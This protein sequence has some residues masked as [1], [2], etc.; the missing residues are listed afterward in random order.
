MN[1]FI[2]QIEDLS[3]EKAWLVGGFLRD[4]LL[5]RPTSDV[6]IAVEG[7]AKA[8]AVRFAR[9]NGS[10]VFAL[11]AERGTYRVVL[12]SSQGKTDFDFSK[13]QGAGI[14]G[15]LLRRDFSINALALPLSSWATPAWR[16]ALIDPT[17]G[18]ADLNARVIRRVSPKGFREDPLRLLRAYRFSAELGFDLTKDTTKD[19]RAFHRLLRQSAPERVREE[20]L[21]LLAT[22]RA[23]KTLTEMDRAGLLSVLFPE[24]EPMRKTGKAYYGAGGVLTH[25]LAAIGS[26]E[27]LLE[28]LPQQFPSF[29]RALGK[30][31][32]ESVGGH[33]RWAHLKLVE[34]FHDIG[35]PATAKK[36]GGKLHFY[37][38]DAVGARLVAKI[39]A[40]LRLSSQESKS[41]SR[42]VGAHMRPGNLGHTPV[43][44]DR[45]IYRFYRDLEG[46]AVGLLIVALGDHFTYLSPRVRRSRKDPVFL[47]IRKLLSHFFL[48]PEVVEPP[49]I[50]DGNDLMKFL[51]LKPSPEVGK[52]LS[53]I[54]ESQAAGEVKTKK[55]ALALAKSLLPC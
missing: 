36:E 52:L 39:A 50:V 45:A 8:L 26:L 20:L 38:H 49:K 1:V 37:G 16:D 53:A 2:R 23:A 40:R 29:H 7:D 42:Q 47:T 19:I 3:K 12:P 15:D 32:Q 48:K 4:A 17:G 43:L 33:P 5:G 22:S 27:K 25:S 34:L 51:K 6:D 14:V 21:L 44:T 31:L 18:V 35:K 55:E 46:D 30:H 11:D 24:L 13:L 10:S 9:A 28:E 41:L 54:R